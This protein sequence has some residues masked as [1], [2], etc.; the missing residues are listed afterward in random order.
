MNLSQKED[1]ITNKKTANPHPLLFLS[2]Q[3]L[4]SKN[5][6]KNVNK[7]DGDV[8]QPQPTVSQTEKNKSRKI[9]KFI[10]EKTQEIAKTLPL[11]LNKILKRRK[12]K[13][14]IAE[15]E[16]HWLYYLVFLLGL[17]DRH[18]RNHTNSLAENVREKAGENSGKRTVQR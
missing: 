6:T 11:S 18:F 7:K 10:T 13:R 3:F 5:V 1:L 14:Q 2:K 17:G 8:L 9:S 12:Q 16:R 4:Y 15:K